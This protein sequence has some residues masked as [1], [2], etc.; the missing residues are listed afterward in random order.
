MPLYT[1][2]MDFEGGTYVQQVMAENPV[3]A[4]DLWA[5]NPDPGM[6]AGIKHRT[7]ST[8]AKRLIADIENGL[9]L[10]V[11]MAGTQSVWCRSFSQG[12]KLAVVNVVQTEQHRAQL[13]APQPKTLHIVFGL[14]A[15]GSIR[16]ALKRTD[17]P[18][19]VVG[20]VD[21]FSHGPTDSTD[22]KARQAFT[23]DVLGYDFEDENIRKT[24][25]AFW[26][27]SLDHRQRRIVW[28]SR[29]STLEYCNFLAW[30][31]RNGNAPFELVDLTD[32]SLPSRLDPSISLPVQCTSLIG[33]DQFVRYRLWQ[34]AS[35]PSGQQLFD[36]IRLWGR[37]RSDDAPLRV[38][39]PEGLVSA[40]IEHFDVDLL[41][42][43]GDDWID[44][45]RIVGETM[46]AMMDD[47]FRE[48][49]VYQCG[50]LILFSRVRA[51]VKSGVLEKKGRLNSAT[52]KVRRA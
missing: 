3:D 40:P 16:E 19:K 12:T 44:G 7:R 22:V 25:K 45:R 18:D 11:P 42:Q 27:K 36:W 35:P 21:D 4:I 51:L 5:R 48:G 46:G 52:F 50:D 43:V 37:L 32:A 13:Y 31:E 17:R 28:L 8:W 30:L 34:R 49:G 15:A 26:R 39:T 6:L 38:I 23:E 20:L 2:I 47:S 9:D 29:W 1:I 14:S 41:A 33:A 24:R 10:L